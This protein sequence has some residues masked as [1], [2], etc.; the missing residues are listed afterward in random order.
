MYKFFF[1]LI[2]ITIVTVLTTEDAFAITIKPGT[3]LTDS[4]T[5]YVSNTTFNASSIQVQPS[6][7]YLGLRYY[8]INTTSGKV[9]ANVTNFSE[10]HNMTI[11]II[12][13]SLTNVNMTILGQ[14]YQV[15]IDGTFYPIN[16]R[17]SYI[18]GNT[19][20]LINIQS[21]RDVF[22]N[23]DSLNSTDPR[24]DSSGEQRVS[25]FD[26]L[27]NW[28]FYYDPSSGNLVYRSSPDNGITWSSPGS[29]N[30]G[31]LAANSYYGVFGS[32]SAVI[33]T[34]AN[35]T[36]VLTKAGILNDATNTISWNQAV[37]VGSLSGTNSGQNYLPSFSGLPN[38]FFLGFN[39]V[40]GTLN[41]GYVYLSTNSGS[42]WALST[43][44]HTSQAN[45]APVGLASLAGVKEIA[46]VPKYDASEF[47]Y[48]IYNGTVWGSSVSTSGSGL[49]INTSK[50]H[51][52]SITNNATCAWI[53]YAPSDNGGSLKTMTY[54]IG[55]SITFS[56]AN[57]G[58]NYYPT[59]SSIGN[60][61]HLMYSR[62]NEIFRI[63]NSNGTKWGPEDTPFGAS[64]TNVNYTHAEK[65]GN[66]AHHVP[67]VWREDSTS[68]FAVKYGITNIQWEL[69]NQHQVNNPDP[70]QAKQFESS[71]LV[72]PPNQKILIDSFND[73]HSSGC[74]MFRSTNG[75]SNWS[76]I[77]SAIITGNGD[78]VVAV[79]RNNTLFYVCLRIGDSTYGDIIMK[80]ST[81]A[82]NSWI[83]FTNPIVPIGHQGLSDK[84][85][86]VADSGNNATTQN[87]VYVCW[88]NDTDIGS[89]NPHIFEIKFKRINPPDSQVQTL[90]TTVGT[91]QLVQ[92]CNMGLG[93]QG[94]VFVIWERLINS[95]S[96]QIEIVRNYNAGTS[97]SWSAARV[98]SV[99]NSF[100][101]SLLNPIKGYQSSSI[102]VT[103]FPSMALSSTGTINIVY[104]NNDPTTKGDILYV[105]SNNC[106]T[107]NIIT[108]PC[109]FSNSIKI[110]LD[111]S[112]TDQF[113]PIL[114][115]SNSTN[116]Q[117]LHVMAMDRRDDTANVFWK[118][119]DYHCHL[120]TD[121]TNQANW[122]NARIS[123]NPS[124]NYDHANFDGGKIG[125]Y[126]SS[127]STI[128]KEIIS[129]W[130][131][132]S[133]SNPI[134]DSNIRS[135]NPRS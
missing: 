12:N 28:I 101:N 11:H 17:W 40:N 110:N 76:N 103:N 36:K 4:Q 102:S 47:V 16:T 113:T 21:G 44:L 115:I 70:F 29:T 130:T 133:Q 105:M 89:N 66:R 119:W 38:K 73:L 18:L 79:T 68:P 95:T 96:G 30:S 50:V 39:V 5:A 3:T 54:C 98:V 9:V 20:T 64:F 14:A 120:D 122:Y 1:V 49:T 117:I 63:I 22:V 13:S 104:P 43:T 61:I 125:E 51:S 116:P 132:H 24:L 35:S 128:F 118:P 52:F 33:I 37:K 93:P 111:N 91:D 112:L 131:D 127:V 85:W 100:G 41:K 92:G 77:T 94:Q 55:P 62:A 123:D 15:K 25:Y 86:L 106:K 72:Y 2:A 58:I 7:I 65:Y 109:T 121:C 74:Q 135:D 78:P 67:I 134:Q 75:G 99:F 6:H 129:S 81:D 87:N 69:D 42:S 32:G 124:T 108:N 71:L 97:G 88:T 19:A 48:E 8:D 34:W 84:P 80:K 126:D 57:T 10:D 53:G 60:N 45:P 26:G 46:I 90:A 31:T 114:S 107:S 82:G 23:F 83:P 59:I 56:T 27:K